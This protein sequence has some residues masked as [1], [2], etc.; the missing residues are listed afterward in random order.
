MDETD[1]R[2]SNGREDTMGK[3]EKKNPEH[4]TFS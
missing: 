1:K 4:T 3:K 2:R